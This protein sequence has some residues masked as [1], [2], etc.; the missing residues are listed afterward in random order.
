MPD[1]IYFNLPLKVKTDNTILALKSW[2]TTKSTETL[3]KEQYGEDI[4]EC[5][6]NKLILAS[7]YVQYMQNYQ[8]AY[9]FLDAPPVYPYNC[10]TEQE[11]ITLLEKSKALTLQKC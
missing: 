9:K 7:K 8:F 10:L 11:L 4:C 5:C 1:I 3:T 6:N 2:L